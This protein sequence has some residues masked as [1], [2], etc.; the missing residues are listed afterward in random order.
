MSPALFRFWQGRV[1]LHSGCEYLL[2]EILVAG[3]HVSHGQMNLSRR[4]PKKSPLG[5]WAEV[6]ASLDIPSFTGFAESGFGE[7]R[8][9]A[10]TQRLTGTTGIHMLRRGN[11]ADSLI[12]KLEPPEKC[13]ARAA[14]YRT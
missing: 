2:A 10:S 11:R 1:C 13:G 5:G 7:S 12:Q 9:P 14:F 3:L 4:I 8:Y 6:S